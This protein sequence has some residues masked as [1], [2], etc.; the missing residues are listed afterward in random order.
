MQPTSVL[1]TISGRDR[2]GVTASFF[3]ALAAHDVDVRDVE[4]VV[5]RDRLILAVLFDLRGDPGALR[6]SVSNAARALGMDSEV[7][8]AEATHS[9]ARAAAR[10]ARA[11]RSH[12]IVIGRPL[13]PGALSHVAQRIADVGANIESITQ[14]STEPAS[15]LE[16][17]VRADNPVVLRAALVQAAED[18]GVDIAV[19]PAGLR[20]RA[21]RLVVLDVDSTL[22]RD[23]AIDVLAARAGVGDQV[24]AITERAMAGELD[25]T[26]SLRAR[27]SL[28]AGLTTADLEAVRDT[29]RLTPGARTFVRTLR[30]V[31]FYVGVVSGGFTFVTDRFVGELELDFAAANNLEV[32]DGVVTGRI[33]GS[34][35]DRAG[36]AAALTR[37]ADQF[38]VPLSQTVAVGDG[39][40]DIDMLEV[41]GLGVAFNA[42]SALRAAADTAVSLPYLD[43]VLF[44]LG[45]SGEDVAEAAELPG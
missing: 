34:I 1:A 40:N 19:E 23:E 35:L 14:L 27:V 25:F 5:I 26:A 31:G 42:K 7:T 43:T 10:A 3:S 36:K 15:S 8:I 6:N 45:I 22:I 12:V 37:F 13:R 24:A 38:G 18:T 20:R 21:K 33:V 9:T 30:R 16:M 41:A 29:L 28:L 17:I 4:Q 39:A 11:S 2:P 44:V 32:V